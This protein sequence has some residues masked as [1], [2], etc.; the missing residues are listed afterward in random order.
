MPGGNLFGG[1]FFILLVLA[2]WSSAISLIE[3]AITWLVENKQISR[4]RASVTAGFA[5]WL[6]GLFTVFS[7]NIGSEWLLFGMTMFGLLDFLTANIMLPLGGLLIAIFSGWVLSKN[8]TQD[9]LSI[10]SAFVYHLWRVAV[11]YIAPLAIFIIFL[12]ITGII[13]YFTGIIG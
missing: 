10:Q 3:P 4:R 11:R 9:E 1:L 2:A 12:N 7:S 5:V 6:L 13:G 8:T